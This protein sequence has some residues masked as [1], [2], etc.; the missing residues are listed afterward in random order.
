MKKER[1]QTDIC[2]R[3][4]AQGRKE[5]EM[6]SEQNNIQRKNENEEEKTEWNTNDSKW[7]QNVKEGKNSSLLH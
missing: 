3:L 7:T 2:S 6:E 4:A 1:S 5:E